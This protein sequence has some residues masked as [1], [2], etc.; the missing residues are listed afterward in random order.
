MSTDT[1]ASSAED[2]SRRILTLIDGIHGPEQIAPAHIEQ[3]TGIK[4]EFNARDS[5][6]YGFSGELSD[7]W[8]Y[9]L[10][11]LTEIDGSRPHRLMFSFEDES[12]DGNGDMANVCGLDYAGYA[13]ALADAGFVAA[14]V[15]GH[16]GEVEY[17]EYER[18]RVSLQVHVRGESEQRADHACVSMIVINA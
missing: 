16:H 17:W 3:V 4:V 7:D 9:S 1:L 5:N 2:I 8:A 15:R 11:S 10:V 13:R 12:A 6:Q 14:P 18:G